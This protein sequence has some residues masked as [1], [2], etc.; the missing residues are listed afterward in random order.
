MISEQ[1]VLK[2]IMHE[3]TGWKSGR[4][5]SGTFVVGFIQGLSCAMSIIAELGKLTRERMKNNPKYIGSLM[6][7]CH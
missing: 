7:Q 2:I 3:R 5:G 1:E 4:N 6:R